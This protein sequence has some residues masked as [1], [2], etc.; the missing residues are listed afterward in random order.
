MGGA[1]ETCFKL[2]VFSIDDD[3]PGRLSPRWYKNDVT[4]TRLHI[5]PLLGHGGI[6]GC[7]NGGRKCK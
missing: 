7:A 3:R 4:I 2:T 6:G 1:D 5:G